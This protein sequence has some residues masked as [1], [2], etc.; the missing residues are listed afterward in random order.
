[1]QPAPLP[2]WHD[3]CKYWA[4]YFNIGFIKTRLIISDC[5]HQIRMLFLT[6]NSRCCS[7]RNASNWQVTDAFNKRSHWSN[8]N[9]TAS[10]VRGKTRH[11]TCLTKEPYFQSTRQDTRSH[12]SKHKR[13]YFS[14]YAVGHELARVRTQFVLLPEY[15]DNTIAPVKDQQ[16]ETATLCRQHDR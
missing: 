9:R 3:Q 16:C 15:A 7:S 5:D 12:V 8:R 11:H 14:K 10:R 1:M 6:H 4:Q 2:V 13:S